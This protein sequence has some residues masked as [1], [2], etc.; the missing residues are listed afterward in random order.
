MINPK[1]ILFSV[2]IVLSFFG[3][4][5]VGLLAHEGVHV[6]QSKQAYSVCYDFQQDSLM[7]VQVL[8][9]SID[10]FRDYTEKWGYMVQLI[11]YLGIPFILGCGVTIGVMINKYGDNY[12]NGKKIQ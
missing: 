12:Y 5:F 4:V 6:L 8:E 10:G 1:F 9:S 7:H 2:L 11:I 3:V